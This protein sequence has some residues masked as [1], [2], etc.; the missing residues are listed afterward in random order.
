MDS[1]Q[2]LNTGIL[3]EQMILLNDIVI[4][5]FGLQIIHSFEE[6]STGFH[7]RWYL[8]KMPFRVFLG[9]EV[10]FNLF[11][12]IVLL[13]KQFP[14]RQILLAIFI[15]LMFAN[16]IQHLVWFGWEKKYVP[17]LLTAPA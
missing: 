15:V 11:W 12:A 4:L 14:E 5:V 17:G 16:G 2:E 6:L 1:C 9:F 7:K 8:F 13:S 3:K 10:L